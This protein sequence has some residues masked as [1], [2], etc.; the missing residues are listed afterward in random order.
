[1]RGQ[2]GELSMQAG[3]IAVAILMGGLLVG[4]PAVAADEGLALTI[5]DH[6][7]EPAELAVPAG[8]K[9][10][11]LV[12]NRDATPEEFE[13]HALDIEK[14]IPGGATATITIGPLDAG[15]YDF[16]GEFHEDSA[17]GAIVAK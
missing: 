11:L 5:K 8:Q 10:K 7:F 16:V 12:T 17:K 2:A 1:M 15:R 6:R 13:S 14:V 3:L 4:G 9:V